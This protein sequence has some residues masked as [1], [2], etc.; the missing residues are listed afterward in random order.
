MFDNASLMATLSPDVTAALATLQSRWGAAAPRPVGEVGEVVGALATVPLPEELDE[1]RPLPRHTPADGV[2]STG[3]EALDAI[4]GTSG[5][6][7]S[8]CVGLRGDG[9]SGKTTIAL[10]TVAQAQATG[11]I[12][13]WLDLTQSF[14]PVEAV[15][16]GVS[17][18]WLV[19]VTP[20]G[21]DEGLSIAGALLS[22][23]AVDLL[24]VDL[25][26]TGNATRPPPGTPRIGDRLHRLV[27][28]AH[29]AESLLVLLEPPIM[30]SDLR[31][32]V[33]ES[34]GLRLELE[35]QG[36]LRLG[37]DVVGQLTEAVVARNRFG[38]PGRRAELRILY[39][40]GDER[41]AC[42]WR[43]ELVQVEP[44]PELLRELPTVAPSI[45]VPGTIDDATPP[46]LLAT[47]PPRSRPR[48]LRLVPE[49]TGHRRR[50]TLDRRDGHRRGPTR[51]G[52]RR[53]AGDPARERPSARA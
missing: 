16:R 49:R 48:P 11:S 44:S 12:V 38:P 3:F 40:D 17:L 42:L 37:R 34:A 41:D 32:A 19:V 6:P 14:D 35:R 46:P 21:L 23:R 20:D 18:D 36:W 22:G 33:T 2:V 25:P 5:L 47:P 31:T 1:P 4:L 29:R 10:R 9:S 51:P 27:A 53:A 15:A 13:A 7:R 28:L 39:A 52:A 26:S 45:P 43:D 30:Q 8:T 50:P 24:V